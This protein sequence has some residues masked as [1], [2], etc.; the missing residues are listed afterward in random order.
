LTDVVQKILKGKGL[1]TLVANIAFSAILVIICF[2]SRLVT[3]VN[4]GVQ[5]FFYEENPAVAMPLSDLHLVV[6]TRLHLGNAS[7]PPD[8]AHYKGLL[9]KFSNFTSSINATHSYIAVDS[10]PKLPNYNLVDVIQTVTAKTSLEIIPV[11][12]WNAFIP[13]LNAIA[14]RAAQDGARYCLFCSAETQASPESILH[15]LEHMDRDTL[16]VGAVLP[17]HCYQ[18]K[19]TQALNGISAPWNTLA[20][21]MF[22]S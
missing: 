16:V 7:A 4:T 13:A 3:L 9:E 17:G 22:Q 11:T 6:G 1:H 18:P 12:P 21:W 20:V 2:G 14:T 19:S 15:L 8:E 10:T 5:L